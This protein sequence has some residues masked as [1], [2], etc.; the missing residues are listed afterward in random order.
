MIFCFAAFNHHTWWFIGVCLECERSQVIPKWC[1]A[2]CYEDR[3]EGLSSET[4]NEG[5]VMGALH[6]QCYDFVERE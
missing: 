6:Q 1:G 4:L 3:T 5:P 2:Q